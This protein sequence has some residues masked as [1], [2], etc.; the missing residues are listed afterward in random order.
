MQ[1]LLLWLPPNDDYV[2]GNSISA[3]FVASLSPYR[4]VVEAGRANR[5]ELARGDDQK[6]AIEQ[7][8]PTY[9]LEIDIIDGG[10]VTRGSASAMSFILRGV[11]YRGA[12]RT[13]LARFDFHARSKRVPELAAQV[14]E[15][16]K[17]GGYL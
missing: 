13:P 17:A 5:L 15:K 10:S 2:D 6:A 14:V 1:R 4:V 12:G 9:R 3:G 16:W 7:F 8:N 11:L